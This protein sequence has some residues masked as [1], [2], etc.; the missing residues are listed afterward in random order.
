[1]AD[2]CFIGYSQ[3]YSISRLKGLKFLHVEGKINK[4]T[5]AAMLEISKLKKLQ[6]LNLTKYN[7]VTNK[8]FE[9]VLKNC[10]MLSLVLINSD[11][12]NIETIQI[13]ARHAILLKKLEIQ[14]YPILD[15][16]YLEIL[17]PLMQLTIYDTSGVSDVFTLGGDADIDLD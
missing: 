8:G 17:E 16:S 9:E 12:V 11:F 10:S 6:S 4:F 3:G 1:M 13:I 14:T 7:K 2:F 15:K 5:D